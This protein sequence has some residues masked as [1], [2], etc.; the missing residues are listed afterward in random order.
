MSVRAPTLVALLVLGLLPRMSWAVEEDAAERPRFFTVGTPWQIRR[1]AERLIED[2]TARRGAVPELLARVQALLEEHGQ[3]HLFDRGRYAT[4]SQIMASRLGAAE[5]LETYVETYAPQAER[6]IGAL[7]DQRPLPQ[8]QLIA[9][10]A[11]YPGTT[12]AIRAWRRLADLA[13]DRGHLG[14]F[15]RYARRADDADHPQRGERLAAARGLL[16]P[17]PP[18]DL[19]LTLEHSVRIWA[20]PDLPPPPPFHPGGRIARLRAQ[21]RQGLGEPHTAGFAFSRSD[22]SALAACDGRNLLVFDPLVGKQLGPVL[23]LTTSRQ[24][25]PV[26]PAHAPGVFVTVLRNGDGYP[27]MV[28]VDDEGRMLWRHVEQSV[29]VWGSLSAPAISE[30]VAAYAGLV[31]A[32]G[33]HELHLFGHDLRTGA[34]LWSKRVGKIAIRNR[35]FYFRPPH[36][37]SLCTHQGSFAVLS[38]SRFLIQVSNRGSIEAI[39]DYQG[40]EDPD[41]DQPDLGPF[42]TEAK[43]REGRILSDGVHLVAAPADREGLLVLGP[44]GQGLQHYEGEGAGDALVDAANGRALLVGKRVTCV[45]LTRMQ[46]L[47]THAGCP[48]EGATVG[49]T[50]GRERALVHCDTR[51]SIHDLESGEQ[52]SGRILSPDER[53]AVVGGMLISTQVQT[54]NERPVA[55]LISGFGL[56]QNLERL[57][58]AAAEDPD[59]YTPLLA[60]A[61]LH[62]ARDE[63]E[64]S[65]RYTLRALALGAPA[66]HG[67]AAARASARAIQVALGDAEAFAQTLADLQALAA[68]VPSIRE[69]IRWWQARHAE[70]SGED[71]LA[72]RRYAALL[73][74]R[75]SMTFPEGAEIRL[76]TLARLSLARVRGQQAALLFPDRKQ[77]T[78]AI[79]ATSWHAPVD[80]LERPHLA[81]DV[82]ITFDGGFLTARELDSGKIRW[83]RDQAEHHKAMLGLQALPE[84]AAGSGAPGAPIR[85]LPGTAADAAGFADGDRLLRFNSATIDEFTDLINAVAAIEVG[86]AFTAEVARAGADGVLERHA[87]T[88]RL[89]TWLAGVAAAGP[90]TV[91]VRR[92]M[93]QPGAPGTGILVP[94][95]TDAPYV[96]AFDVATGRPL[97]HH[98]L[99]KQQPGTSSARAPRVLLA[100]PGLCIIAYTD[101]I[102]AYRFRGPGADGTEPAWQLPLTAGGAERIASQGSDHLVIHDERNARLQVLRLADGVQVCSLPHSGDADYLLAGNSAYTLLPSGRLARWNLATGALHWRSEE[103]ELDALAVSG[104]NLWVRSRTGGLVLLDI[105]DGRLRQRFTGFPTIHGLVISEDTLVIHADNEDHQAVLAGIGRRGGARLWIRPLPPRLQLVGELMVTRQGVAC[106]LDALDEQ[107]GLLVLDRSGAPTGARLLGP[108]ERVIPTTAGMLGYGPQGLRLHSLP[109]A[110]PGAPLPCPVIKDGPDFAAAVERSLAELTFTEL[111][112]AAV[113]FGKIGPHLLCVARMSAD[114]APLRVF[115][116][117]AGPVIDPR[118]QAVVFRYQRAPDLMPHPRGWQPR[119]TVMVPGDGDT[120]HFAMRLSPSALRPL[121]ARLEIHAESIAAPPPVPWWYRPVW[122]PVPWQ[123]PAANG[124][125]PRLRDAD[126]A[127]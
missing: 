34:P 27:A 60:L 29:D 75:G 53:V 110:I 77:V 51:L 23:K 89:G 15:V 90:E 10:A 48:D 101:R 124:L 12:A 33:G 95:T 121:D 41:P 98:P 105:H 99:P 82:V 120:R 81:G 50:L 30:D 79:A 14:S 17:E 85:V 62:R 3:R 56:P 61:S 63:Y 13:W 93:P 126:A 37:P 83:R 58:Q 74:A 94:D 96:E 66:R 43:L 55:Q 87:L 49:G 68:H 117:D 22:G 91:L 21:Q 92:L 8:D 115:L 6:A 125:P 35:S 11:T 108:D 114:A 40:G 19:P 1:D 28:A 16:A 111:G 9:L 54:D 109:Q 47:W 116:G 59:D 32:G 71:A 69:E 78:R 84:A 72:A 36:P 67:R 106:I 112:D 44:D 31:R 18:A 52:R 20:L 86:A 118:G 80:F 39:H 123:P 102:V 24:E 7:L 73:D 127:P 5:L 97:W 107:P 76:A 4:I 42:A 113:A 46:R 65:L 45:D 38:N 122:H 100:D 88:G 57:R 26:A 70:L 64:A 104:D 103:R 2:I 25:Q 119:Q